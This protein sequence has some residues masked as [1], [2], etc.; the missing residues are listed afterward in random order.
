MIRVVALQILRDQLKVPQRSLTL[1]AGRFGG[2]FETLAHVIVYQCLFGAFNGALHGL[3][4]LR[5]LSA[6]PAPFDHFN[7]SILPGG[8]EEYT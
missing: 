4:F 5:D 8:Y 2:S 6:G 7:N 1:R 3:Q